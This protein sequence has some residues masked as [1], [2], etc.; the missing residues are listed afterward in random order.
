MEGR[1]A[2]AASLS[3]TL[4]SSPASASEPSSSAECEPLTRTVAAE[5]LPDVAALPSMLSTSEFRPAGEGLRIRKLVGPDKAFVFGA[6]SASCGAIQVKV[7][8]WT[9]H[10]VLQR[11]KAHDQDRCGWV[12]AAAS[13]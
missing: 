1:E 10:R 7:S 12:A 4:R 6:G 13:E 5:S 11:Y 8:H 2:T 9:G 3:A